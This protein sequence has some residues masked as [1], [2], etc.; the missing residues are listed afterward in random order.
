L[1]ARVARALPRGGETA[2]AGREPPLPVPKPKIAA[3]DVGKQGKDKVESVGAGAARG[4]MPPPRKPSVV[5]FDAKKRDEKGKADSAN[6]GAN[7]TGQQ[8]PPPVPSTKIAAREAGKYDG[9]G[10]TDSAD[11]RT[12]ATSK[13]I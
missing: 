3:L 4:E 7:A 1:P 6:A 8:K 5:A 12:S 13:S 2:V 10:K 11:A 9:K